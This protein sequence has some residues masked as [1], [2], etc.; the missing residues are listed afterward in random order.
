MLSY[1][2]A[3]EI[4]YS[5]ISLRST[6][7]TERTERSRE[8]LR[9]TGEPQARV[10]AIHISGTKGKGSVAAMLAAV[11]QANGRRVGLYTSPHL[12]SLRERI[13]VD[14]EP[15][16]EGDF[17]ALVERLR[18][19]FEVV[20]GTSFPEVMTALAFHHFANEAVDI[21][22]IEVHVGGTYDATNV[23]TPICSVIN[24]IA[25]DHTD[26][27]GATLT[28]IATHKAGIIKA[29]VPVVSA[30]QKPEVLA[31]L[32]ERAAAVGAPL[33]VSGTD[34]AYNVEPPTL[35]EQVISLGGTRYTTNLL[36]VH[37]G[38]N[39][40]LAL[41]TL[42]A[43]PSPFAVDDLAAG[44]Q[45]VRWPGRLEVVG[46][47]PTMLLDIAHNVAA[48]VRLRYF[49]D[50]ALPRARWTF[51]FGAKAGKDVRNMLM[52]ITRPGDTVILTRVSE[53]ATQHPLR[54][55]DEARVLDPNIGLFPQDDL[56]RGLKVAQRFSG[57]GDVICVTGSIFVV[58]A[59]RAE[60]LAIPPEP[61]SAY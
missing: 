46:R 53:P 14:G 37:Q 18:A 27:L 13:Q 22:V 42:Q 9:R 58:A 30:A 19:T 3:L 7:D 23:L 35:T 15:V 54:L 38:D 61:G 4:V 10:P 59:A 29:G 47:R 60:L 16:S 17:A 40:A 31:V 5:K 1:T 2:D 43:L 20:S 8:I 25:Y 44:L 6:L 56:R 28:E 39:L 51:V 24:V 48:A 12:H 49:R 36:G 34:V 21:V 57:P 50:M 33:T 52:T 11:L 45:D 26:V 55:F 41:A 32:R